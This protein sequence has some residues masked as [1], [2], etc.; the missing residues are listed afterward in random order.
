MTIYAPAADLWTRS[1]LPRVVPTPGPLATPCW[2][3]TGCVNSKG[4][5]CVSAGLGKRTVL[6]HRL[7]IA[8]RDGGLPSLPVDHLCEV[9]RCAN[10]PHLEPVTHAENTR[11]YWATRR[12]RAAAA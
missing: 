2:I 3:F 12:R 1:V 5:G 9:K 11:R 4:Y 8:V 10:P 6:V 7:A